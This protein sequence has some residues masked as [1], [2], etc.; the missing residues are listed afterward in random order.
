[1]QHNLKTAVL[2]FA[3]SVDLLAQT[4]ILVNHAKT[5][6]N[7]LSRF[8]KRTLIAA[9]RSGFDV[10]PFDES[11]Q[12]GTSF[13]QKI[14]NAASKVFELGYDH[15]I[16]IGGDCPDLT[17]KDLISVNDQLQSQDIILGPDLRGGVYAIGLRKDAFA[18]QYFASLEW[19][20]AK[21]RSSF[22]H[23]ARLLSKSIHWLKAKADF[24]VEKDVFS[25]WNFS[26]AIR[27]IIENLKEAICGKNSLP[28][29]APIRLWVA[30]LDKRGP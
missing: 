29:L 17:M 2:V 23:Y 9:N 11:L 19:Q 10:I 3:E 21:L 7:L 30:D 14:S 22:V 26:N 25:Y 16:V 27:A 8:R 18:H 13:G 4:K 20:T 15:V 28:Q 12:K 24:N 1:M 5:N 6:W